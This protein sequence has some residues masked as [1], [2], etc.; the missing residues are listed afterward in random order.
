MKLKATML[1]ALACLVLFGAIAAGC[2]AT[3]TGNLRVLVISDDNAPLS[4]AKVVSEMQPEGQLKVTGGT[5]VGG[6]VSFEGIAAGEYEFYVSRFD[7][8]S[9]VFRVTVKGGRTS[10][11]TITL[12]KA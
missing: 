7:Y 8:E 5:D 9:K 4:G 11:V 6:S 10:E 2:G 1:A 3:W 12:E